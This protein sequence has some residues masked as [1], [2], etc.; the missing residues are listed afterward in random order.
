M[1]PFL[2]CHRI[3]KRYGNIVANDCV[4]FDL[5][6][7]EVHA[8][9]GENGAGKSTLVGCMYGLVQ[10]EEGEIRIEGQPVR[11]QHPR[12]ALALGIGLVQ[13]HFVLIPPL[14]VAENI[15]LG[16]EASRGLHFKRREAEQVV[17]E[18][19]EKFGLDL[20]PSEKVEV[21]SVAERQRVEIAKALYRRARLLILDE[22]TAVLTPQ[23]SRALLANLADLRSQGLGIILITHRVP[24]TLSIADRVTVLRRGQ[25]VLHQKADTLTERELAEAIVGEHNAPDIH[26]RANPGEPL[27]QVNRLT[28]KP[29]P[30]GLGLQDI[31]FSIRR[32][33]IL[34]VAGV[35]GNGQQELVD[36]M[37]GLLPIAEGLYTIGE[38]N[39]VG[40]STKAIRQSGVA[41]ILQDRRSQ[42]LLLSSSITENIYLGHKHPDER[43][44]FVSP[45]HR[46]Q[47]TQRRIKKFEIAAPGPDTPVAALSG[48]HQQRVVA[49][50]ELAIQPIFVIAHD[51]TRGLD[52]RAAGRV[53]NMILETCESGASVLLISS[54]LDEI[55]TMATKVVVLYDG[56]VRATLDAK[57]IT[58][59]DLGRAMTG[60]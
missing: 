20:N 18:L 56:C 10:P 37:L 38:T 9:V 42:G 49:A 33:E 52:V 29:G 11:I 23:E 58:A 55:L 12:D 50:R 43:W 8:L 45:N 48:G 25:V 44:G 36:A 40:A 1:T 34:G 16:S 27:V 32:G 2:A 22:P 31:S 39:L 46:A 60:M 24:E 6:P 14:S 5:F 21:L 13:Q 28:T 35:S 15:V 7:G 4:D 47:E 26:T 54:D 19:C 51:P 53:R 57:S 17:S 59:E 3:T 30:R 41:C